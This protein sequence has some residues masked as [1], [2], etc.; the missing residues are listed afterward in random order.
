MKPLKNKLNITDPLELA[1]AEERLSK[2]R[3]LSLF[4]DGVLDIIKVGTFKGLSDIH[5][6]LFEEVYDFVPL[7]YLDAAL[8]AIDRMPQ[9]T[10]DEIVEKYVEMNVA[11]PFCE[12]NGR[13]MRI[14]LDAMLR[15]E[16]GVVVDWSL[17][18]EEDYLAAMERSPVRDVEIK[19]LLR[20]ALTERI[21]D[22]TAFMKGIDAS[23]RYEGLATYDIATLADPAS[24]SRTPLRGTFST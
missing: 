9:S 5:R 19:T 22:R 7:L 18:D 15:K 8:L 10:F 2:T 24:P 14:W 12:G 6:Y 17:V 13:S 1:R 20:A 11:H 3:A 23:Y 16:L 4:E 21:D